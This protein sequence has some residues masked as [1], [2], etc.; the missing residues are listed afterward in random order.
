[1]LP[2]FKKTEIKWRFLLERCKI[3]FQV[4]VFS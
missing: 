4:I 2:E 1:M 3:Y